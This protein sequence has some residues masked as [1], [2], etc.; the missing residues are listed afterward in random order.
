M[1]IIKRFLVL[2][3]MNSWCATFHAAE[4]LESSASFSSS[5]QGF[6]DICEESGTLDVNEG[7]NEPTNVNEIYKE[8]RERYLQDNV[9]APKSTADRIK[10]L[11]LLCT[12]FSQDEPYLAWKVGYLLYLNNEQEPAL[13]IWLKALKQIPKRDYPKYKM[14]LTY[15]GIVYYN[16]KKCKSAEKYLEI[17]HDLGG[18]QAGLHLVPTYLKR[19]ASKKTIFRKNSFRY[20]LLGVL[21]WLPSKFVRPEYVDLRKNIEAMLH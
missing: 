7:E 18:E 9:I 15:M 4:G 12:G 8:I 10:L 6:S 2:S 1:K 11:Q 3:L 5:I 21:N 16:L 13:K 19:L 14:M 20:K 17:A